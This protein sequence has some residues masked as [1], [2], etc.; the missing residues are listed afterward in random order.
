[1]FRVLAREKLK[2]KINKIVVF[3]K[4]GKIGK[5]LHTPGAY[6]PIAL[7]SSIGKIIEKTVGE[8]I[9]VAAKRYNLL[10]QGQIGNRPGRST[11][12]IIRI[13]TDAVYT[14]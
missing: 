9:A 13:I 3:T 4:P 10:P 5:V 7:L 14:T 11:E 2:T 8:R 6:R 1:V 12:L